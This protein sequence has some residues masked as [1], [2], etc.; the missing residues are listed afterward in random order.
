MVAC[1]AAA[2][3]F[4]ASF[5][6]CSTAAV[7]WLRRLPFFVGDAAANDVACCSACSARARASAGDATGGNGGWYAPGWG[8]GVPLPFKVGFFTCGFSGGG[9]AAPAGLAAAASTA[10]LV[11]VEG[12]A[13]VA[14]GRRPLAARR[15]RAAAA[16]T[17]LAPDR[18][19]G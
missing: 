17:R 18:V 4:R 2:R 10:A 16:A 15:W 3:C 13:E 19:A 1:A 9:A 6:A 7:A 11:G 5:H 8:T 12:V 14:L